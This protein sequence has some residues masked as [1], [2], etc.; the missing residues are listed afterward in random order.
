[1][2]LRFPLSTILA[3]QPRHEALAAVAALYS[4]VEAEEAGIF[5]AGEEIIRTPGL[6]AVAD[7]KHICMT[8]EEVQEGVVVTGG[9][10]G[11]IMISHN[12]TAT[13]L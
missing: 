12:G 11:K 9:S 6:V 7:N 13:R 5:A 3:L 1:M 8:K 10:V 2:N 4:V